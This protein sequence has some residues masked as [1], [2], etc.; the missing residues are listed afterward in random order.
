MEAQP[1]HERINS[2]II[3]DDVSLASLHRQVKKLKKAFK[4]LEEKAIIAENSIDALVEYTIA[5]QTINKALFEM[6]DA[7]P[8]VEREED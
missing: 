8:E 3:P 5:Q 2:P 7:K 1:I 6:I 4:D